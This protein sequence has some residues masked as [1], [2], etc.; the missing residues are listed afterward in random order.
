MTINRR[1]FTQSLAIGLGA[2]SL[3]AWSL[4]ARGYAFGA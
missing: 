1:T 2:L 4:G 3:P